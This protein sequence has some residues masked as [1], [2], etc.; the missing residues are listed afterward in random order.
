MSYAR[1]YRSVDVDLARSGT[2]KGGEAQGDRLS[3][4]QNLEGTAFADTLKGDNDHNYFTGGRGADTIDGRGGRDWANYSTS[5]SGVTV[6]L[7]GPKTNGYVTSGGDAQ[8][9]KL[10]NIEHLAGSSFNDGLTGDDKNNVLR[11]RDSADELDGRGGDDTRHLFGWM[12]GS[13]SILA[14]RRIPEALLW[15]VAAPHRVTS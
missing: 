3:N 14:A 13:R 10:R 7:S 1:S 6:N 9:D 15:A 8:G 4:I 12:Q 2:Q 5:R 11:G